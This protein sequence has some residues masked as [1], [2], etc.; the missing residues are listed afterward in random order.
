MPGDPAV[1][2]LAL[3]YHSVA[4]G[5]ADPYRITVSPGRFAAQMHWLARHGLRGVSVRELLA[6]GPGPARRM[7]GLTFDDGY[8][9]FATEVVPVLS[10][11]GFTATV[12][13]VA[14][15]LGGYNDWDRGG[16]AKPL[17]TADQARRVAG[18]GMEIGSHGLGHRPLVP[19][20]AEVLDAEAR[21]SKELLES[22]VGA[23]VPGFCY[24]YGLVSRTAAA[25]VERAGYEYAVAVWASGRW[26]R[27]A[28][29]R[30]Y[31]GE[32]DGGSRLLAKRLR[33]RLV[34]GVA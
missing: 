29:P 22:L 18:H 33:H 11:Y 34:W 4:P 14:G 9:D 20:D 31:V 13:L 1:I 7:V 17:M 15:K 30:T 25:A 24:P 27:W 28:L 10:R 21:R 19:A 5:S 8:A 23:A 32:R 16:P 26:D 12:Y 2:P 6:A 3:M